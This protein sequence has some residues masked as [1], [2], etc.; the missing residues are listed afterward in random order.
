LQLARSGRP[1]AVI[2]DIGI[3]DLTGYE[4]ARRLRQEAWGPELFL[5]AMTGWG[6][7]KDKELARQAGFD[8]HFTKPLDPG[9]LQRELAA[10]F[11]RRGR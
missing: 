3:P 11:G 5:V 7:V 1:H 4:V 6:Q 2:L 9:E 10:F 8:R